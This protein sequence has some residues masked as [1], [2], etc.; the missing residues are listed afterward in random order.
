MAVPKPKH[1]H[2]ML[3]FPKDFLWGA[4]T[5]PL[6]V[7][8]NDIF[9][10]WW[11]WETKVQPPSFRS[12][13]AADQYDLFEE[14]FTLAQALGHNSH[15]LGIE[16]A[17]IEP[18]EGEFDY[19]E[20]E[21]YKKVLSSLQEKNMKVMLTL[22]HFSLPKWVADMGGFENPK[23]IFLFERFIKRI[24][25]EIKGLV[26]F[27][28]TMNEPTVYI[29]HHYINPKW[30][31]SKK[32]W[33]GR[34]IKTYLNLAS[35]HKKAY[36]A[37]HQLDPGKPV[38]VANNVQSF[39]TTHM[40]SLTELFS[41]WFSDLISN[42]SFYFLT[43]GYHDFYGINYYIHK[44]F[45]RFLTFKD[46]TVLSQKQI[47]DVSDLGWEIYPEGVFDVLT[48]LSDH[49]P[50]Y[51]TECG[52]ATTN[53]DRKTRFLIQY[54]QEIYRA[55]KTGVDI[56]GFF[57][58]SLID[59]M[60]LSEGFKP[61]FGLIEVDFETQKRRPRPSAYVYKDIIENNGIPHKL[62]KLLGHTIR[63]EDVI[64]EV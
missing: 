9:S 4:A 53:D 23:V 41:I 50:I 17:K 7:E 62:L 56:R 35:G 10:D 12:G 46:A 22:W 45:D 49:I 40:H 32:R 24:V 47:H 21:H 31:G 16:W 48:D 8:G 6:Q 34:Q 11:A 28:I 52:I 58:W 44:R 36:T 25:P 33:I 2:E 14:D 13:K 59:N 29:Y 64:K 15:R 20:I 1:D 37:I 5:S 18:K 60:E 43:K 30:P 26:D 42:H 63:V 54:L 55:I 39:E 3:K 61:R 27:W 51:I 19:H 38:G 57:Y